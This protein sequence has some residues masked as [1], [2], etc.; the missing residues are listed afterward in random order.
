MAEWGVRR[1]PEGSVNLIDPALFVKGVRREGVLQGKDGVGI[2]VEVGLP[3][4]LH[5]DG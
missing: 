3:L 4:P 5:R 1:G 2:A